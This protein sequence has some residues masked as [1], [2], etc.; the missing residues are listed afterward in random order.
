M[1]Q[2]LLVGYGRFGKVYARRVAEH[3]TLNLG[4]VVETG[5]QIETVRADGLRVFGNIGEA[6]D[7]VHPR[8]VIVATPP[9]EHAR[10]GLYALQRFCHVMLAKPGALGL[11]QAEQLATTAWQRQRA[12]LIDYTPTAN[13]A[14]AKI[15]RACAGRDI[16]TVRLTR[17]GQHRHQPCGALYDLAPHDVAL[18]LDLEPADQVVN[19]Y[20]RGW[21]ADIVDQPVGAWLLLEHQSGRTTRIEVDW[22][23]PTT[24]RTVEITQPGRNIIWDQITNDLRITEAGAHDLPTRIRSEPDDITRQLSRACSIITTDQ[25]DDSHR[26]LQVTRILDQ[27]ERHIYEAA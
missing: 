19:V 14:W 13:E 27:A 15:S 23:S 10:M 4:G 17:R 25:A 3:H 6:I 22:A 26:L 7:T 24:E 11:D 1:I 12:L 21:W 5:A 18:A 16:K 20:A 9:E 8:L 2:T